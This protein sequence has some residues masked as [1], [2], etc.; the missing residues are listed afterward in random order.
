MT[1]M[2]KGFEISIWWNSIFLGWEEGSWSI[3]LCKT[4]GIIGDKILW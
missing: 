1:L 4:D 3:Y 2:I